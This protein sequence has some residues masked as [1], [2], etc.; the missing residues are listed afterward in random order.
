MSDVRDQLSVIGER[1]AAAFAIFR[2]GMPRRESAGEQF[3]YVLCAQRPGAASITSLEILSVTMAS[4]A[5]L[6]V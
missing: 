4:R 1:R 2:Y 3:G 5:P 6:P